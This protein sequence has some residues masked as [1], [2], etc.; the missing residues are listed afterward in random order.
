[1]LRMSEISK[2]QS[3][4]FVKGK[5][6]HQIAQEKRR[7]WSTVKKLTSST[8][9]DLILRGARKNKI[10]HICTD[11]VLAKIRSYLNLEISCNIPRKQRYTAEYI[12]EKLVDENQYS[13]SK[14]YLRQLI[15]QERE[16]IGQEKKKSKTYLELDFPLGEYIQI[17]HGEVEVNY[18][19]KP[20]TGYLFVCSVPGYSLRFCQF[21]LTKSRESWGN[22]HEMLFRFFGGVFK[23]CIYDNDTV[24]KHKEN[25]TSYFLGIERHY[26]FKAIF[27]NKAAGWEKGSVENAVGFCRRNYMAGIVKIDDLSDFN[28]ELSKKSLEEI[29]LE[30]NGRPLTS[31]FEKS[32]A[33]L[34]PLRPQYDWGINLNGQ[35][36]SYQYVKCA[37]INYSVPEKYAGKEV[38][39]FATPYLVKIFFKGEIIAEHKRSFV[40]ALSVIN[41]DHFLDQ[42]EKKPTA[43]GFSKVIKQENFPDYLTELRAKLREKYGDATSDVEFVKTLKLRRSCAGNIFQT[44]VEMGIS[45]GGILYSYIKNIIDQLQSNQENQDIPL[46]NLPKQCG[47]DISNDFEIS[48]YAALTSLE[49]ANKDI[50]ENNLY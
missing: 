49:N 16:L 44:A 47:V 27:C 4:Y 9:E 17:D 37:K 48:K 32:K 23:F 30:Q 36:S 11:Q 34:G 43:I 28:L 8:C 1:M 14:R 35:V 18:G 13:G 19:G 31:F 33:K 42:L 41:I 29:H 40:E 10:S 46:A 38:D 24:L 7:S 12:Y 39:V 5:T 21:Y 3:D 15:K 25:K 20:T 22:F 26:G 2:I 50:N 6:V 45:Y